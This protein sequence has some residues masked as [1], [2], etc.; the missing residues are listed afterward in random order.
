M[1]KIVSEVLADKA[2]YE[3]KSNYMESK[4]D[5]AIAEALKKVDYMIETIGDKFPS[6][7]SF[8]NVYKAIENDR[9]WQSGFWSGI[10]WLSYELTGDDKYK[11]AALAQIDSYYNRIENKIGILG[12]DVGFLYSLSCVAAYKLTGNEKAK[13]AAIM[14]AN[15]LRSRFHEKGQF[16]QAWGQMTDK[17]KYRLIVDC[18]LNIPILYWATEATGDESYKNVAYTHFRTTVDVAIREDGSSF[19]TYYFDP[20]TGLPL[21]GVTKQ[22]KD[23]NSCWSRGHGWVIYGMMLTRKYIEDPDAVEICRAAAKY[24]LNRLPKDFIPYWD[25]AFVDGDGEE[26]DS[27]AAPIC[28]CGMIELLKYLPEGEEKE[29][30]KNAI[31]HSMDSLFENYS[32]KDCPEAN[33]LLLHAVYSKP[34][35]VGIDEMNIW[36]CYFYL[37]ALKRLKSG[38]NLYW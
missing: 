6:P 30:Y 32:T 24:Y 11:N 9:G 10:L 15:H 2:R 25:L 16:I 8:D 20:E 12:H 33:G 3:E 29:I 5:L 14:A 35:K 7:N 22:G 37:E 1:K 27:S 26:K 4:L 23:D 21:R 18:L 19:H 28:L 17:T 36:G 34:D 13:E 31:Y 38:W